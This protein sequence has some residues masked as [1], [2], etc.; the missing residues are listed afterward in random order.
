MTKQIVFVFLLIWAS[1]TSFCQSSA[2]S[3][4][5]TRE[6][7][8]VGLLNREQI[9]LGEFGQYFMEEYAA[10]V[11][12]RQILTKLE[13]E[14]YDV[15]I[16]IVM[17]TWCHDSQIQ[18]PHFYKILD[19]LDYRTNQI[20]LIGVDKNKTGGSLDISSFDIDYVPTFIFYRDGIELGRIIESPENSLE[21]DLLQ[22]LNE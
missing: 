14:I 10:Y 19:Q 13:N 4:T 16:T 22:I 3:D 5:T 7:I 17:A 21:T 9:Q 20:E 15:E 6:E 8:L 1:L 11:P 2:L 12:G 18:V